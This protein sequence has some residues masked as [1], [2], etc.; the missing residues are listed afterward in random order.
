MSAENVV[1]ILEENDD[2]LESYVLIR[3]IKMYLDIGHPSF[4]PEIKVKIFMSSAIPNHL[5]HF[6]VSHHVHTPEQAAPYYP[7][8]TALEFEREAIGQAIS[9]TTSFLKTALHLGHE[10]TESWLILNNDF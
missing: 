1:E 7:S 3:E 2:V 6:D 8:R 5:F 4:H 10:P 9:T